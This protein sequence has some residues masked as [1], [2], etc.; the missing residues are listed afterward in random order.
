MTL[1]RAVVIDLGPALGLSAQALQPLVDAVTMQ[2][3]R[4]RKV[5][6]VVGAPIDRWHADA[7]AAERLGIAVDL[8][9]RAQVALSGSFEAASALADALTLAGLRVSDSDARRV[10]PSTTG[11]PL[12]ARPRSVSVRSVE[13]ALASADVVVVPAGLGVD[14]H[15]RVTSFGEGGGRLSAVF[16]GAVLALPVRT[17]EEP[18]AG[19]GTTAWRKAALL[20]REHQVDIARLPTLEP[21]AV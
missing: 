1:N 16:L 8:H 12:D 18:C 2:V 20:A 4:G 17:A 15:A 5:I 11:H 14:E 7:V 13:R 10:V 6:A 3:T 21:I 19:R 9:A